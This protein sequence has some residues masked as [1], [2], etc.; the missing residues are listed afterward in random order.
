M[1]I[2]EIADIFGSDSP[3]LGAIT[4][5][6]HSGIIPDVSGLSHA[7]A[8]SA[9]SDCGIYVLPVDPKDAKNPGSIVGKGWPKKSTVDADLA[10]YYWGS[11]G[12][13]ADE[14][15]SIAIHT[16]RSGLVVFDLDCDVLPG[17]LDW[18]RNG[19]YQAS[20]D[21]ESERGHYVFASDEIFVSGRLLLSDGTQVGE[22]RS[23][24]SV[25][26]AE[27]SIHAKAA[28][29]G[30][31]HWA[32]SGRVPELPDAAR[33]YL[34]A[35]AV[36]GDDFDTQSVTDAQVAAF[37]EQTA[38]ACDQPKKLTALVGK[39]ARR[40]GGTRDCVRDCLR[41]AA[42]ESRLGYYPFGQAVSAV[43]TAARE[44]YAKRGESYDEHLGSKGFGRLV[45]NGVG[46][47]LARDISDIRAEASRDYG[48][49]TRNYAGMAG[50]LQFRT[51]LAGGEGKMKAIEAQ[52]DSE[53]DEPPSWSPVDMAAALVDGTELTPTLL[54]RSDGEHL[55]YR[56]KVHS[57][58]GESESGKTWLALCAVAECLLAGEPVLYL[59]FEDSAKGIGGRLM[60][61]GVP[62]E[63]VTNRELFPYVRPETGLATE[64]ERAAFASLLA[65]S[66]SLA[67]VDGVTESMGL[68]GLVGKDNDQIA[69][70]QRELPK[71]IARSTGAA[72]VC[73]DHVTKD[74]DSRGRFA[75]GGQQKMN[76][77]DG[78]AF[79]VEPDAP[80]ARGLAGEA[81]VRVG[82]DR[83]GYLRAIGGDWR[84]SDRTQEIAVFRLD[85]TDPMRAVWTV[86]PQRDGGGVTSGQKSASAGAT[87]TNLKPAME[88]ISQYLESQYE[89]AQADP[90]VFFKTCTATKIEKQMEA[91]HKG[92]GFA[93]DSWRDA[94]LALIAQNYVKTQ[95]GP[96]NSKVHISVKP[97][98]QN[99]DETPDAAGFSVR[100]EQ[101]AK[102]LGDPDGDLG[103]ENEEIK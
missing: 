43:E 75:V 37:I 93:R 85:S 40:H 3:E 45:A 96:R 61:L 72:V 56:G 34:T 4:E 28:A 27:P 47:A 81:T 101:Q 90:S 50:G 21:Y 67:V 24:N 103:D 60:L 71:A 63:I 94:R 17:E 10:A 41:I 62:R 99:E 97:Y 1:S 89:K 57:L 23:G 20:R 31:Y 48:T 13:Y 30:R 100:T 11:D 52:S 39:L 95:D 69:T 78:A 2:S 80:F 19:L 35:K 29:G 82:K 26:I 7:D 92:S 79:L 102:L 51:E 25:I 74:A 46:I 73:I 58:H 49:D 64:R 36:E 5:I 6:P 44:S 33:D 32:T 42:G 18:L 70:W 59:D 38:N 84:K 86:D 66:Y 77:L 9:Y 98:N 15:P 91:E 53:V 12:P 87:Y 14:P 16:G 83:P 76:G 22:I 68:F 88:L 65:Q 8:A 55:F 54:A